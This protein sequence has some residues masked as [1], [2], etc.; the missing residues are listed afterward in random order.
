[1][2]SESSVRVGVKTWT[3]LYLMAALRRLREHVKEHWSEWEKAE[4]ERERV[5]KEA[6]E[7]HERTE[8]EKTEAAVKKEHTA[9]AQFVDDMIEK[10]NGA[11]AGKLA[12][13]CPSTKGSHAE[14]CLSHI[15]PCGSLDGRDRDVDY[16]IWYNVT[17]I[18]GTGQKCEPLLEVLR[19]RLTLYGIILQE[20]E[21]EYGMISIVVERDEEPEPEPTS[22]GAH[23]YLE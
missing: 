4:Q 22:D 16:D 6:K 15:L 11:V 21:R 14:M 1:M 7:L 12:T 19:R 10:I 8:K 3:S 20:E 2:A 18:A 5:A 9:R 23:V 17:T 13:W